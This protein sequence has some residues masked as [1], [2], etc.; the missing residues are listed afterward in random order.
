[1]LLRYKTSLEELKTT[2][3]ENEGH[4]T[5]EERILKGLQMQLDE[6]RRATEATQRRWSDAEQHLINVAMA[7]DQQAVQEEK[8]RE[9]VMLL[10]MS[11]KRKVQVS[12][13]L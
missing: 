5:E 6:C 8:L 10:R 1:M 4:R 13:V 3:Q 7:R 9:G 11:R 12:F 2:L